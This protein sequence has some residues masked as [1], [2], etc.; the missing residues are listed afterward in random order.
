MVVLSTLPG[1]EYEELLIDD[2]TYRSIGVLN[3]N[4]S[5]QLPARKTMQL[6]YVLADKRCP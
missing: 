6:L 4:S 2:Q 3:P 5:A 1:S